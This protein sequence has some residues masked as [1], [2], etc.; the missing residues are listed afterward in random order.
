MADANYC[1][2]FLNSVSGYDMHIQLSII[3]PGA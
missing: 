3:E 2:E 1:T